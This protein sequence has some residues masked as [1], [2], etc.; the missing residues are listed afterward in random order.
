M[1][2]Y[3]SQALVAERRRDLATEA[4]RGRLASCRPGLVV[5][6]AER[7]RTAWARVMRTPDTACCVPTSAAC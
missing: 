1:H 3:L 5:R 7:A 4:A 2:P 6:A